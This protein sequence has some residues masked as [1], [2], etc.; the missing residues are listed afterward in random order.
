MALTSAEKQQRYR[1]RHLGIYGA[2]QRIQLFVSVQ[3]K[4]QLA[5][6]ARHC[7]Y[8]VTNMIE[9]L[10]ADAERRLLN[11]LPPRQH[12]AYLDGRPQHT[13]SHKPFGRRKARPSK[14]PTSS[15]SPP[16]R[17]VTV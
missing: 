8:T 7:G 9:K 2:K 3:A 4:A 5:R 14:K 10:A 17:A 12:T 16:R 1:Q 11:R 13:A 6:L 15:P